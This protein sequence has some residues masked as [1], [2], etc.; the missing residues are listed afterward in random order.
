ME[1]FVMQK[2]IHQVGHKTALKNQMERIDNI[3][4]DAIWLGRKHKLKKS[5]LQKPWSVMGFAFKNFTSCCFKNFRF[6]KF[7][8]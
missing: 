8:S 5:I 4:V 7:F 3:F 1:T 6:Q 2:L